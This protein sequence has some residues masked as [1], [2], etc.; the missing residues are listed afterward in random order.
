MEESLKIW[1]K[2]LIDF[3]TQRGRWNPSGLLVLNVRHVPPCEM[4]S[5]VSRTRRLCRGGGGNG[6]DFHCWVGMAPREGLE[7]ID[8]M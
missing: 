3:L 2:P 1:L 8:K 6:G 7:A 4:Q 5:G